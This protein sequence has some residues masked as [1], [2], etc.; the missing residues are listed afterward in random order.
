V[1]GWWRRGASKYLGETLYSCGFPEVLHHCFIVRVTAGGTKAIFSL[2]F[3]HFAELLFFCVIV[4]FC[5]INT[6]QQTQTQKK[7]PVSVDCI[8]FCL[9]S[10]ISRSVCLIRSLSNVTTRRQTHDRK[11]HHPEGTANRSN[12]VLQA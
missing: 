8:P 4:H 12:F 5:M 9:E 6:S 10:C 3:C 7:L 2:F 1:S 11:T